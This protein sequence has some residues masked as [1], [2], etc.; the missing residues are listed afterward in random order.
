M[1]QAIL[2]KV[3]NWNEKLAKKGRADILV[4]EFLCWPIG[5]S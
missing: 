3:K 1:D 2:Y 4:K 5:G